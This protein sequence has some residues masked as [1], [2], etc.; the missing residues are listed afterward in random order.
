MVIKTSAKQ[1]DF[2]IMFSFD[3]KKSYSTKSEN[4]NTEGFRTM[5][6]RA[7]QVLDETGFPE[8]PALYNRLLERLA[9]L[10]QDD[11]HLVLSVLKKY[12]G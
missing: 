1:N 2:F 4:S 8:S 7:R 6:D 12:S 3:V 5:M 9:W 10:D 11:I